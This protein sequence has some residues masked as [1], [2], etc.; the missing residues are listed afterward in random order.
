S[1]A[2]A[3]GLMQFMP[4]TWASYGVDGNGDGRAD[5]LNDADSV[6][7]AANYLTASGGHNGPDGIRD[8]LF[9]YNRATWYVNDVLFYAA[10]YG[11]GTVACP[12]N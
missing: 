11:G 5:I 2:G 6:M 1:S 4:A 8:A 9:A 12:A 10:A 7:S 3:Q